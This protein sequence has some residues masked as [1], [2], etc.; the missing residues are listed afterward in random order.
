MSKQA[1]PMGTVVAGSVRVDGSGV[2]G[3][4]RVHG[5]SNLRM[6]DDGWRRACQRRRWPPCKVAEG[7]SDG[8]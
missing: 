4:P 2:A 3:H 6:I 8:S 7:H 5:T 1:E